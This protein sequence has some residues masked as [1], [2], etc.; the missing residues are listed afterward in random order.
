MCIVTRGATGS[1]FSG[2]GPAFFQI[3]GP[4][5]GPGFF[6]NCKSGHGPGRA[7]QIGLRAF[8]FTLWSGFYKGINDFSFGYSTD[9]R[10][11]KR[12]KMALKQ[13]Y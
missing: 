3:F 7:F 5:A 12:A 6:E 10:Y 2:F 11:P 13:L 4:R 9:R 8:C 1:S